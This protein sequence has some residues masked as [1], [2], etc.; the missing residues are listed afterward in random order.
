MYS[1]IS[2]KKNKSENNRLLICVASDWVRGGVQNFI[3]NTVS[4]IKDKPIQIDIYTPRQIR[5][6]SY[7]DKMVNLG[8]DMYAGNQINVQHPNY[9][10]MIKDLRKLFSINHYTVIHVNTGA[11]IIQAICLWM[12]K[13][14]GVSQRIAHSHS[15]SSG[16]SRK[17]SRCL[18]YAT[19]RYVIKH[20]ATH[21]LAC[22]KAAGEF[23]YG[24]RLM[25]CC[26]Q[27][28]NNGIDLERFSFSHKN[29][30]EIRTMLRIPDDEYVIG[31]VG[32]FVGVKN[33]DFLLRVFAEIKRKITG[34]RLVLIGDN[35]DDGLG[36]DKL[37]QLVAELDITNS[38]FFAGSVSN[39][40]QYYS[41]FDIFVMPSLWEG[42]P[43]VGVEAQAACLPCLFS[44]TISCEVALTDY[45]HF[46]SLSEG[47]KKWADKILSLL[48]DSSPDI[49][50]NQVGETG[51]NIRN[52]GYDLR[53]SV[54]VM[55]NF[56]L[57]RG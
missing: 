39:V 17:L 57:S 56:Y 40:N 53:E 48:K 9:W 36:K 22:S 33:H 46:Y 8:V 11:P 10:T 26:G 55:E 7:S 42:L 30:N 54:K 31:H 2:E 38:V 4:S 37:K 24:R 18:L 23:L 41:A 5:D 12:A 45:A 19:S 27:V 14:Y 6:I 28:V 13:K 32:N 1:R 20:C 3:F 34:V 51:I 35:S 16:T 25:D 52:Q 49:R 15:A 29:R 47:T 21:F 43:Y 50:E 44:D